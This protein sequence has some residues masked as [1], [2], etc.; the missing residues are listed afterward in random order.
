M[1][2]SHLLIISRFTGDK[3]GFIEDETF[4]R[5]RVVGGDLSASTFQALPRRQFTVDRGRLRKNLTSEIIYKT[6][7][8][9]GR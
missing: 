2:F 5:S 6:K 3:E 4:D 7:P 8:K 1:L 9:N